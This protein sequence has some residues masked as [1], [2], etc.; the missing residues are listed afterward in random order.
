MKTL[1]TEEVNGKEY[2]N[3]DDARN[4][5]GAFIENAYNAKRLHS[6]LG[7]RPPEEF[8]ADLCRVNNGQ[9]EAMSL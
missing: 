3:L 6:A 7:Y 1:K 2:Q 9:S 5:I 4:R 8:E